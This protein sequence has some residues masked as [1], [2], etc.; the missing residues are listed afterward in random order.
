VLVSRQIGNGQNGGPTQFASET[1]LRN[2]RVLAVDQ[3]T[4]PINGSQA[5][6]GAVATIEVSAEDAEEVNLAQA[7]GDLA[8]VLRSYADIG[9]PTGRVAR[10]TYYNAPAPA[11]AAP[12]ASAPSAPIIVA[13]PSAPPQPACGS[14]AARWP[15][16]LRPIPWRTPWRRLRRPRPPPT[17]PRTPFVERSRHADLSHS[18]RPSRRHY[19]AD[20]GGRVR[21]DARAAGHA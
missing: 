6:I 9:G 3:T 19:R 8:L 21:P 2:I 16:R 5:V 7:Q 13:A 12:A 4:Q 15:N 10:R 1:V 18:R 17:P 11:A 20:S 14:G